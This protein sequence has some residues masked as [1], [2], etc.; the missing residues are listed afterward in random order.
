MNFIY[1]VVK[2][3]PTFN[4]KLKACQQYFINDGGF[5]SA[6]LL[7][8]G[9]AAV[10]AILYY[11]ISQVSFKWP[12]LT[13]WIITL[14]VCGCVSFF[15]TGMQTGI[16][17]KGGKF[18]HVVEKQF[19]KRC[20]DLTPEERVPL[21]KAQADLKHEFKKSYFG[22]SPVNRLCWTNFVLSMVFFYII[23]IVING[24]SRHGGNVPHRGLLTKK[25]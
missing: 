19:N 1:F 9:I 21:E 25:N 18:P 17:S 8:L 16:H 2:S 5:T 23:S 15:A 10:F 13:T 6:F 7:A 22:S 14:V 12:S 11:I 20:A 4:D 24:L 3:A